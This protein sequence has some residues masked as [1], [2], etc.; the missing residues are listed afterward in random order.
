MYEEG[1]SVAQD[2]GEAA[3]WLARAAEQKHAGAMTAL[4]QIADERKNADAQY[5]LG[6]MYRNGEGVAQDYGEA[7]QWFT[8][9]A[10]EGHAHAQRNLAW[11]YQEGKGVPKDPVKAQMWYE[12]SQRA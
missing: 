1:K 2:Y 8:R 9:A 3:Q 7:A 6:S 11:M 12:R 10:E 4:D 5:N